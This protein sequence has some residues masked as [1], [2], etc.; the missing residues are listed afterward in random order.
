MTTDKE[1]VGVKLASYP[2]GTAW[3]RYIWVEGSRVEK[4]PDT[5]CLEVPKIR[6]LIIFVNLSPV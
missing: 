5:H 4:Q 1:R 6:V 2:G 3:R